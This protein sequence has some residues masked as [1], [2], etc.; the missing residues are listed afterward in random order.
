MN[1]VTCE[2]GHANPE[3]TLLCESCGNP[4]GEKEKK[5]DK[6]LLDMKYEGSARRS[7]TYKKTF[8]DKIWNF[9]SSVKVGVWLIFLTLLASALGTVFPQ[10]MYIPPSVTASEFYKDEYGFLGHLYYELGFHNLYG[11]WWY[12]ILVASIGISLVIASLDRFVPLYR[13]LKKQGVTRHASFMKRQRLYSST[14]ANEYDVELLKKR[15]TSKRYRVRVENGNILAEKGRFS[16][17]GPYVNHCGLIIFLFGAMLRFV[18]GMYVDEVLWVREGET[19][20]IPGTE[21]RYYLENKDFIMEVYEKDKESEVFEE[22]ITRVGDGSVVKNFQSDVVL[23]ERKG[24]IVHGATPEL[25]EVKEEEIRVN[26]P[27][28]F[29]SFSLYQV[30]YKLNE[31]NKMTFSLIDKESEKSYGQITVDLLDPQTEYDLGNGYKVEISTY[32]PD[33]YFD[34]EGVPATKT[35]IPDNPAFVFKMFTPETPEGESSFVA[36]QQTIEPSG[37]NKYKLK[38]EG[39][40]T[41]DLTAL[42]VRKDLTLW[43]L[44]IGGAIFMI[45]VIQGMYW[46][47]RRIW[48]KREEDEVLVAGHTNKNWYGLSKELKILLEDTALNIPKDQKEKE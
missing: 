16:R 11:S 42:T 24:E 27:L 34:E 20:V 4:I 44:G 14:V 2:C 35:R 18:P 39:I 15:L 1:K 5:E 23:Y 7:Q 48:I 46:N 45:G 9:F 43:I 28:K 10:E 37:E 31:L 3:G 47:H 13:A 6:K 30:D 32:L 8:V 22:A 26:E 19:A 36:I 41:K 17:W 33:F 38:F 40:E 29:E 21:G 25:T 12:M